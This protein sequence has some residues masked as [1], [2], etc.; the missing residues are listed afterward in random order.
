MY[1]EL[2]PY[3]K[4]EVSFYVWAAQGFHGKF[5]DTYVCMKNL[6]CYSLNLITS[7]L[8]LELILEFKKL[9]SDV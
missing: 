2:N 5:K 8:N 3:F 6:F 7:Y 4:F 1:V 9:I